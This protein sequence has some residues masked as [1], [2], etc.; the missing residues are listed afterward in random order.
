MRHL[1]LRRA[2]IAAA[3]RMNELGINQGVSGN[4]SVRADDGILITPS[5]LSY[6]AMTPIDV[7][8]MTFDGAWHCAAAGRCPSS[9]WRFHLD[10]LRARPEFGALVHS[11]PRNTTTLACHGRG[12]PAFH[13]M[14]ALAGGDSIRCAPYAT[15]GSAGLSQNAL[16]A[17]KGRSACLLANHGMIACGADLDAALALALEVETLAAQ[18]CTAL[19]LGEPKTLSAAEMARVQAKMKAGAGYG[20][21]ARAAPDEKTATRPRTRRP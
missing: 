19:A 10:I 5:G 1:R 2:V 12:I 8:K 6:A 15:F 4:L 3:R 14:V 21:A 13:Y 9:E 11:H 17:L 18:Y 16:H 7:V 20:S